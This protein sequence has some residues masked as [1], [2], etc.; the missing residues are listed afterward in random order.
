MMVKSDG[1][2]DRS[3]GARAHVSIVVQRPFGGLLVRLAL[4][5][6]AAAVAGSAAATV[7]LGVTVQTSN[8]TPVVGGAAFS[9]TV[10]V[11]NHGPNDAFNVVVVDPMPPGVIFQN[12]AVVNNP[13]VA[14]FGLTCSGPPVG[15]NGVVTCN[16]TLPAPVSLVNSV[17]T[18][19]IVAQIVGTVASGVRTNTVTVASDS[20]EATPNTF[21]N[22]ASVQQNL[23]VSA[24]LSITVAGPASF[25]RGSNVVYTITVNNGGSSTALN[26][27]IA[28]ALP[29]NTAFVSMFGTGPFHDGCSVSPGNVVTCAAV[30]VPTGQSNLTIVASTSPITPLG[31]LSNTATITTA[32]TGSIAVGTSTSTATVNP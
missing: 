23:T 16:G 19:T 27:T 21:P 31:P 9:Y 20:Q 10:V 12:V 29:A 13:S 6:A 28:D 24:P 26:A 2:S 7:D 8:P 4:A 25:S 3:G 22:T 11:T 5:A 14:G 17:T 32:G 1:R 18:I 30:D 15:T